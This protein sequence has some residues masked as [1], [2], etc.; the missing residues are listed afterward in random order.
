MNEIEEAKRDL[1]ELN[2]SVFLAIRDYERKYRIR[3]ARVDLFTMDNRVP[4]KAPLTTKI[5]CVTSLNYS[6]A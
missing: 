4:N 3:I 1:E 5:E 6:D 2:K